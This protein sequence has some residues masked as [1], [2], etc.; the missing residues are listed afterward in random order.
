MLAYLD[1][2]PNSLAGIAG[3][4]GN[5]NGHEGVSDN[6]VYSVFKRILHDL[7]DDPE[8]FNKAIV[9]STVIKKARPNF[10]FMKEMDGLI[11]EIRIKNQPDD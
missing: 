3:D 11:S 7:A 1:T 4:T 9:Y 10:K 2:L 8:L 5:S 6:I